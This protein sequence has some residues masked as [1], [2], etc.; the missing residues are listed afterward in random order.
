MFVSS[1]G[2]HKVLVVDTQSGENA[3]TARQEYPIFSSRLP[4]FE[5]SIYECASHTVFASIPS[6]T[7]L[8]IDSENDILYVASEG[9]TIYAY[10]LIASSLLFNVTTPYTGIQG[11]DY[12][13]DGK[14]YFVSSSTL[15]S[16]SISSLSTCLPVSFPL[17]TYPLPISSSCSVNPNL[18]NSS[19]FEQVHSSSGYAAHNLSTMIAEA[20]KLATEYDCDP[21]GNFNFDVLLLSGYFCHPCLPSPCSPGTMCENMPFMGAR[22]IAEEDILVEGGA[23]TDGAL[24][25]MV[26]C[27]V[28]IVF[29]ILLAV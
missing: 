5:Y 8:A 4:S 11:M 26:V 20:A 9:T 27:V 17:S 1:H 10:S 14:L 22:C 2:D 12:S 18:P 25:A 29:T 15:H 19:L 21:T 16:L 24:L 23:A 3:R 6:P 13:D 7:G 28:G